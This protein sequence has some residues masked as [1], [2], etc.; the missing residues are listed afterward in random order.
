MYDAVSAERTTGDTSMAME[1]SSVMSEKRPEGDRVGACIYVLHM[2]LQRVE[3]QHPGTLQEMI[4][5][6]T[7]DRASVLAS[8]SKLNEV[9]PVFT[10]ALKL[11]ALARGQLKLVDDGQ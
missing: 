9:V 8:Q 10:E 11:L 6:V 2:L 7:A 5:G 3:H 1:N 4:D